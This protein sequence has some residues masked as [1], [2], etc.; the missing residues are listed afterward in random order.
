MEVKCNQ[1]SYK[2]KCFVTKSSNLDFILQLFLAPLCK[3]LWKLATVQWRFS[4]PHLMRKTNHDIT[5]K[6]RMSNNI[7]IVCHIKQQGMRTKHMFTSSFKI[8]YFTAAFHFSH[9]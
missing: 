5:L 1:Q 7:G 9:N 6:T 8:Q 2:Q 4:S 3:L